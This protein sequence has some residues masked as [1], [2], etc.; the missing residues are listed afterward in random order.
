MID[1]HCHILPG[2]DDGPQTLEESLSLCRAAANDGVRT[3]VAT[4]HYKPGTYEW[5]GAEVLA[6]IS[7]LSSAVAAAGINLR[8]LPGAEV[9][10]FPELS[11]QLKAGGP[12]TL[13]QGIYFLVE[14]RPHS[15]PANS[16]AFLTSFLDAGLVPVIAHP[17]RNAWFMGHPE[18]LYPLV[19][20]GVLLQITAASLTGGLGPQARDFSSYLLRH[21]LAHVIASDAHDLSDR[22]A[23]LS[24]AVS[25]A[26]DLVGEERAVTMVTTVPEAIIA[27][28]R[29]MVIQ[30]VESVLPEEARPASFFRRTL[31]RFFG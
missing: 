2:L 5:S 20:R 27:G 1:I 3:I 31:Q 19:R 13:N 14:F 7:R 29:R 23:A 26:A 9:S 21:D 17:E 8:I 25:L 12:L 22:P 24:R 10:V 6:A 18:V 4:P 11:S 28:R 16:E 30:P 15:I